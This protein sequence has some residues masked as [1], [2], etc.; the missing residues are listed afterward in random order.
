MPSAVL[1]AEASED[2]AAV[3]DI[4]LARRELHAIVGQHGV[5][6]VRDGLDQLAQELGRL[7]LA[8]ATDQAD[9]GELAGA[10]DGHEE[11][12]LAFLGAGLGEIDMEVADRV[13]GEMPPLRLAP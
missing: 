5:D 8:G 7:R 3:P 11:T 1:F 4:L 13:A 9:E 2:A 10:V 12:E 6:A